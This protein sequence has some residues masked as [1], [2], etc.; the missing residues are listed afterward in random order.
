VT[1]RFRPTVVG[2]DLDAI[3]HNVRTLHPAGSELM[4]IVKADGYGHGAVPVAR[5]AAEAGATWL[6]VALVEEGLELRLAGVEVP[7]LVLSELPR[8]SEPVALAHRLTPV[9]YTP[10][11][12]EAVAAAAPGVGVH[13]KVDTGMHRVGVWPPE[14]AAAF[15]DMLVDAGLQ[16][17]G[18]MTH[19]AR[20]ED[21]EATTTQ[22]LERFRAA[23]EAVRAAGHEPTLVHAAN[24]GGVIRHPESHL[25]LVRPGISLYGLEPEPGVGSHIDLRPALR[26]TSAVASARRMPAGAKVSY[27]HRYELG[28]E[29]WVATV[30]V[31]YADGYP[32]PLS[33]LAD[34][35]IGGTRRRV[36]GSVT[37]DQLIVLCGQD[38]VAPGDEVVLIGRQGDEEVTAW[39]L[40]RHLGTVAWEIVTRIGPRVPREYGSGSGA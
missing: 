31:G 6:G 1:E 36:I 11:G 16:V 24:S 3:R 26:W 12:V 17:E 15:C 8:G 22:Q 29:A 32:R 4:A 18:L 10:E 7:I 21:D 30:P 38:E 34:V 5:A 39:E 13:V 19:L 14:D 23:V 33:N 20:S 28:E 9:V 2:V 40:A 27:G 25:D 35:L 37:M